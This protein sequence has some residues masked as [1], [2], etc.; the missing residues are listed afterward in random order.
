MLGVL[1]INI[2]ETYFIIIFFLIKIIKVFL[3]F[4]FAKYT[5]SKKKQRRNAKNVAGMA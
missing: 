5:V 1:L 3:A 2:F 4:I